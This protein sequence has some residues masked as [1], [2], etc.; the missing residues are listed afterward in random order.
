MPADNG[1]RTG[2]LRPGWVVPRARAN[3]TCGPM[4]PGQGEPRRG[5]RPEGDCLGDSGSAGRI[6]HARDVA[7]DESGGGQ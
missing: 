7:I 6:Q 4:F 1:H 3:T 2:P 5:G